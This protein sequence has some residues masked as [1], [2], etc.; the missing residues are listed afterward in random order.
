MTQP[1]QHAASGCGYPQG[2]CSGDC[3]IERST[4]LRLAELLE[5]DTPF[6][7]RRDLEPTL[8]AAAELRRLHAENEALKVK[9]MTATKSALDHKER[10]DVLLEALKEAEYALG[11]AADMTKPEGLSGCDCPICSVSVKV[12]AAIAKA[13]GAA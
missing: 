3:M 4:S 12:R 10:G 2:E 13:G 9:L 1:C 5:Q 11:Y 7:L 8:L 6:S